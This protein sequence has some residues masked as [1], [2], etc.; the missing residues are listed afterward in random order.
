[1]RLVFARSTIGLMAALAATLLLT[2][3]AANAQAGIGAWDWEHGQSFTGGDGALGSNANRGG[4]GKPR[5]FK[6]STP[7]VTSGSGVPTYDPQIEYTKAFIDLGYGKYLLAAE[8][9][10]HALKADPRNAKTWFM[11]G[12]TY[13]AADDVKSAAGA[14][15]NALKHDP[16]Q[17]DSR[18]EYAVALALTGQMDK[19]Q[20]QFAIL[21]SK[22]DA[23]G[24]ACADAS[25]LKA[26]V[27]RV[28][29]ALSGQL[30]TNAKG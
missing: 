16:G 12:V 4:I 9:F 28:Q 13:N 21:K 24:G 18:R 15:E 7:D 10:R 20:A 23:C 8:E 27:A 25:L 19:A 6:E 26:S 11:L 1:V 3:A 22:A 2:P 30:K 14:F 5:G 17:I 29:A